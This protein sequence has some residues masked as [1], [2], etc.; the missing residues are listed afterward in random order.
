M[1]YLLA[2]SM[3]LNFQEIPCYQQTVRE[4]VIEQFQEAGLD[5][6]IAQK[7]VFC[8]SR[9]NV[10]AVNVNANGTKDHGLYQLNSKYYPIPQGCDYKCQTQ[11]AIEIV[12]RRGF[13]EWSCWDLIK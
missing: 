10:N 8:E 6:D 9:W 11:M 1:L 12:K 4:Y 7:L 3:S 13:K 5:S 2:L